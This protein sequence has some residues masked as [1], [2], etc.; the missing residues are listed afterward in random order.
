MPEERQRR[1]QIAEDQPGIRHAQNVFVFVERR[2]VYHLE[3]VERKRPF[4]Q[5][6]NI[7]RIL[8]R[9]RVMRPDGRGAR[10]RIEPLQ[11]VEFHGSL[12]V[13]APHHSRGV[14]AH[15][16]GHR[17]GIRAV[18]DQV[19][20]AQHLVVLARG[21]LHRR[22]QAFQVGVYIAQ[23]QVSHA[24]RLCL[25]QSQQRDLGRRADTRRNANGADAARDIF[26]GRSTPV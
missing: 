2:A 25:S 23:D 16:L 12:V 19:A 26:R 14:R 17:I 7:L 5:I 1:L 3:A 6:A 9:Q 21:M 13:I 20:A 18:A 22:L 4:G 24:G 15:P 10:H 11:V 8:R